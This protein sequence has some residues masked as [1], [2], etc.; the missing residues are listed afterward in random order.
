MAAPRRRSAH[1]LTHVCKVGRLRIVLVD[2]WHFGQDGAAICG[3]EHGTSPK[4]GLWVGPVFSASKSPVSY[5]ARERGLAVAA[6]AIMTRTAATA[7]AMSHRTQ[8]MPGL[9]LPPNAV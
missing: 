8:S 6:A 4:C 7:M 5:R 2:T 9:P 1:L 3:C